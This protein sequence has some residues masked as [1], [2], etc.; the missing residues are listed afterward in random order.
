M[1]GTPETSLH[2]LGLPTQLGMASEA[3][4]VCKQF[5][6]GARP[7]SLHTTSDYRTL[8]RAAEQAARINDD[9]TSSDTSSSSA[10]GAAGGPGGPYVFWLYGA[11][12]A[13]SGRITWQD[14]TRYVLPFNFSVL[15]RGGCAAVVA[16][17]GTASLATHACTERG[18]P[19]CAVYAPGER[20]YV[21]M[22]RV[23][24]VMWARGLCCVVLS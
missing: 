9:N 15:V 21:G 11:H 17:N 20:C 10:G 22:G 12:N 1:A 16:A 2:Y 13:S 14:G 18:A 3:E 5:G 24:C 8:L 6:G 4:A 23:L 19:V 7:A